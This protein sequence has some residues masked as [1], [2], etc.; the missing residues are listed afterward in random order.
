MT[1]TDEQSAPCRSSAGGGEFSRRRRRWRVL[2][3]CGA[4]EAAELTPKAL[5][6]SRI[7]IGAGARDYAYA[8]HGYQ[9]APMTHRYWRLSTV[10]GVQIA[11][12]STCGE[13][14]VQLAALLEASRDLD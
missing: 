10:G 6:L 14:L 7:W 1:T 5:G 9:I 4:D 8:G 2:S 3:E 12:A 13:L 11:T